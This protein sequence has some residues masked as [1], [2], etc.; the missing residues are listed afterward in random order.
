PILRWS[1]VAAWV[2]VVGAVVTTRHSAQKNVETRVTA[3]AP[4]SDTKDASQGVDLK[5]DLTAKLQP[6]PLAKQDSVL[7]HG[8]AKQ[9]KEAAANSRALA[10]NAEK[11]GTATTE[12][13]AAALPAAPSPALLSKAM[14]QERQKKIGYDA[15]GSVARTSDEVVINEIVATSSSAD[16]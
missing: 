14:D 9:R 5:T 4:F 15:I 11:A 6:Q 8:L 2:V 16:V 3:K 13:F 12:P 1:A 10:V 7:S